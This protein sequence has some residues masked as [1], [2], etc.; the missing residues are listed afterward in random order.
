MV[1]RLAKALLVPVLLN[2]T[3]G[4]GQDA[5]PS[6]EARVDLAFGAGSQRFTGALSFAHQF[7]VALDRR[8]RI[9]YGGRYSFFRG[10]DLRFRTADRGEL[11]GNP[12][13][14]A[15]V[16]DPAIHALNLA[17]YVSVRPLRQIELGFNI[18]VLGVGFGPERL[19]EPEGPGEPSVPGSP[20]S[21]NLLRGGRRDRGTLDSE[22][23]IGWQP[24]RRFIVR[25]GL[26]HYVA[27]YKAESPFSGGSTR[28]R[29]D[30]N[31]AF[32]SL[33]YRF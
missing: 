17:A 13:D 19:L 11:K 32:L 21:F 23:Y 27:E 26:S 3:V 30:S 15:L 10:S 2:P 8:L 25:A 7:A 4:F 1:W 5:L 6:I 31:L 18:D 24:G 12:T 29:I 20:S 16:R 28:L 9:G 22:F 33:G 14:H